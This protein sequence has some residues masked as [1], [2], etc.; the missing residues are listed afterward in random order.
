VEV[1]KVGGI[2]MM[3]KRLLAIVVIIPLI[4]VFGFEMPEVS[5]LESMKYSISGYITTGSGTKWDKGIVVEVSGVGN[6]ITDER[7]YFEISDIP[8]NSVCNIKISKEGYLHREIKDVHIKGD[9]QISTESSKL[10]LWAGDLQ[11]DGAI[12]MAD[13]F[14]IALLLNSATADIKYKKHYDFNKDGT[15]NM[16]DLIIIAVHFG[17]TSADYP[18]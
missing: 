11:Q 5:A 16:S 2:K 8:E 17:K 15:I 12:N 10:L 3:G 9:V 18:S 6:S 1:I 7:G 14:L 13:V 4:L